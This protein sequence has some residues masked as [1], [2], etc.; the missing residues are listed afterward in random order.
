MH[1]F[2]S[3]KQSSL[4]LQKDWCVSW[5]HGFA[6]ACWQWGGGGCEV[7]LPS[8]VTQRMGRMGQSWGSDPRWGSS[9]RWRCM[10]GARRCN[11]P[12]LTCRPLPAF[13]RVSCFS[14]AEPR[15]LNQYLV[16]KGDVSAVSVPAETFS[17]I[18]LGCCFYLYYHQ[19]GW[20]KKKKNG[21]KK[22]CAPPMLDQKKKKNFLYVRSRQKI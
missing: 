3:C 9:C 5:S 2:Y 8:A 21:L 11:G 7:S 1:M 16:V 17:L 18:L 14:L 13:A 22:N 15:L 10:V 4:W 20:F 19:G 12:V 6:L